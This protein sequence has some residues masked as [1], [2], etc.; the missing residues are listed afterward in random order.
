L[1]IPASIQKFGGS[2]TL[3]RV[4][5][6]M[7]MRK[8]L[9]SLSNQRLFCTAENLNGRIPEDTRRETEQLLKSLSNQRLFCTA[10]GEFLKTPEERLNSWETAENNNKA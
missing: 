9:K 5:M 2:N 4:L 3:V 1:D 6:H 10:G 8:L 7:L